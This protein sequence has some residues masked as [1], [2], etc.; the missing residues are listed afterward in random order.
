[1]GEIKLWFQTFCFVNSSA[2]KLRGIC[3]CCG[4]L[5]FW[6]T[7]SE[8]SPVPWTGRI[9]KCSWG[10]WQRIGSTMYWKHIFVACH[11]FKCS[12]DD[13]NFNLK[14]GSFLILFV[15]GKFCSY[16]SPFHP[17][18]SRKKKICSTEQMKNMFLSPSPYQGVKLTCVTKAVW[19]FYHFSAFAMYMKEWFPCKRLI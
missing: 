19:H 14:A 7:D 3:L 15:E 4:I 13:P 6:R 17:L 5:S 12:S 2:K 16:H 8:V 1:M 11:D 18:S 10:G 9:F